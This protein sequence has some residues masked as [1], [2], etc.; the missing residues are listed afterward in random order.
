MATIKRNA[1]VTWHGNVPQGHGTLTTGS[2]ALND[3]PLSWS[4]RSEGVAGKTNPEELLAA[5]HAECYAM[6]A[7]GALT[8]A[9]HTPD[10]LTVEAI[11][12]LDPKEGGGFKISAMELHLSGRVPGLS[13]DEFARI[14]AEAE[15]GCPVSNALRQGVA[16]HL[17]AELA[18]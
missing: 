16:I 1:H 2:N 10:E 14:A 4:A 18:S 13:Q 15:K 11:C 7:S 8:R 5:A 9:G 17:K 3:L 12:S 6:S